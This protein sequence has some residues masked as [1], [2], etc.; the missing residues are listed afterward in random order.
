MIG[1][2]IGDI[3]G[4]VYELTSIKTK[5]FQPLFH[6]DAG[7]TD[8]S[9]M[10]LAICHALL[11][12]ERGYPADPL[13]ELAVQEMQN[14]G[15]L[16]PD[17]GYG[18]LF[19]AWI[20][21]DNP[22]PYNSYGNGAAMRVSGVAHVA[23]SLEEVRELAHTVTA[24]THNHPEGLKGAEATAVACYLALHGSSKEDIRDHLRRHYYPLDRTLADIRPSYKFCA[25]CQ[26]SVPEALECFLESTSF[27]D[28]LRNAVSLG[29]D[30][31]T[32]GAIAGAVAE[33]YYGVPSALRAQAESKLDDFLLTFLHEFEDTFGIPTPCQR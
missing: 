18:G 7:F 16:Y 8:D 33:C 29:G 30:A 24:V 19:I 23:Q 21:S 26:N 14:F 27:E 10:S 32:Q 11:L 13:D 25:S 4:S 12:R 2:I 31:D 22:R 5:N 28:C 6:A 20:Y 9:V 17:C 1:A 15:R 3:V